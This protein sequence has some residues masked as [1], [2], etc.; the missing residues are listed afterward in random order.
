MQSGEDYYFSDLFTTII[1]SY[2]V[3]MTSNI[4]K[5]SG[6]YGGVILNL[7]DFNVFKN[8]FNKNYILV[9]SKG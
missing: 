2:T 7:M 3:A 9:N 5:I 6:Q 1:N 8:N 4:T